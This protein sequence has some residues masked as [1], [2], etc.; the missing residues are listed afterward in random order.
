MSKMGLRIMNG[1]D[2]SN[3]TILTTPS[4]FIVL[5]V[6]TT[7]PSYA[8]NTAALKTAIQGSLPTSS[9][10]NDRERTTSY[11][12]YTFTNV[13]TKERRRRM[14]TSS[15]GNYGPS[16]MQFIQV[17]STI[18]CHRRH[19]FLS[20]EWTFPLPLDDTGRICM[21]RPIRPIGVAG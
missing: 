12:T 16:P 4:R 5:R 3:D 15:E 14:M 13:L 10:L 7:M 17:Q 1:Y 9:G 19:F 2:K 8:N 11:L 6:P 21:Q 18:W 20:I